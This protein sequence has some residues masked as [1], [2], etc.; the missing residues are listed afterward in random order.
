[1]EKQAGVLFPAFDLR[2]DGCIGGHVINRLEG[3]VNS[4]RIPG[5]DTAA[6]DPL[7]GEK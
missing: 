1:M 3:R 5:F 7:R 6:E 2:R 4:Y